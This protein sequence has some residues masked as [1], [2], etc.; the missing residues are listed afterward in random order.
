MPTTKKFL[1]GLAGE[2]FLPS[3]PN[4][5]IHRHTGGAQW[6]DTDRGE[7]QEF[8]RKDPAAQGMLND[9]RLAVPGSSSLSVETRCGGGNL[10]IL[11]KKKSLAHI[12]SR[13]FSCFYLA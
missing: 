7:S 3:T 8:V 10:P 11:L 9:L 2:A 5:S 1:L 4:S 13:I 12:K 6:S